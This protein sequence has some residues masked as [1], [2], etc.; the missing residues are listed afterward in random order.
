M[1]RPLARGALAGAAT[2]AALVMAEVAA[3]LLLGSPLPPRA[4]AFLA[5]YCVPAFIIAGALAGRFLPLPRVVAALVWLPCAVYCAAVANQDL[6]GGRPRW[7]PLRVAALL[8]STLAAAAAA[9]TTERTIARR[10]PATVPALILRMA[11]LVAVVAALQALA[12]ALHGAPAAAAL[13]LPVAASGAAIVAVI[14]LAPRAARQSPFQAAGSAAAAAGL[15]ALAAAWQAGRPA[16]GALRDSPQPAAPRGAAALPNV[17]LV[18]LDTVRAANL[19][20]YG[21]ER[22]TTPHLD[23]FAAGALRYTAAST[24]SPWSVPAHASLFTGL[25]APEHGA[26]TAQRDAETGLVRPAPLDGRFE[27][28]AESLA[29]RG[30]A[31]AGISANVLVAPHMNLA[32]GFLYYDVRASPRALSPRYRTLLQR[33]QG[34]LPRAL[35][36][37]PL[38]AAFPGVFRSAQ[39]ITDEATRR[40]GRQPYFLFLNYMDAHTPYVRRTGFGGR[41]PGRSPRLPAYGLPQAE[42]VMAHRRALSAEESAHLRALYDDALSYLDHHLGRLFDAL[43]AQTDRDRTWIDRKSTRLNSS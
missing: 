10:S 28:L 2:G 16:P 21:Y 15:I 39:E 31:T 29:V 5:A 7:A 40:P 41:W 23:A 34:L 43:D 19:S 14:V 25:F 42:A 3:S 1:E 22:Q 36:A 35:L 9:W 11:L 33:V 27:T 12:R 38:L 20:C 26:G 13:A 17:V 32:Q 24:V 37:D 18:V 30:Y 6:L 8:V 4:W